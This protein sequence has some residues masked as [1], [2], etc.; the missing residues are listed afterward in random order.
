MLDSIE[1]ELAPEL[2]KSLSRTLLDPNTPLTERYRALFTLRNAAGTEATETLVSALGALHVGHLFRHDVAFCLGQ[3]QDDAAVAALKVTR[4]AGGRGAA[5]RPPC[6]AD[7]TLRPLL[8]S[9]C[10]RTLPTT[11]W[12][13]TRRGRP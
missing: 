8:R 5:P 9:G 3:R 10:W 11:R 7:G 6:P 13:G 12:C 1:R 4:G 2:V